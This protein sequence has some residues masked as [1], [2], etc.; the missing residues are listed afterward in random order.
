MNDLIIIGNGI[1]ANCFLW[2]LQKQ[3]RNLSILKIH[4]EKLA[5]SCSINS[6]ATISLRGVTKGISP[7][8]DEIFDSYQLA[9]SFIKTEKPDGVSPSKFFSLCD[10][11][12]E[13]EYLRRFGSLEQIEKAEF[14]NLREKFLGKIWGGYIFD[15]EKF[16]SFLQ[17]KNLDS[18]T[19]I[20]A[21]VTSTEITEKC[22]SVSTMEGATYRAK[23]LLICA[24]AYSKIYEKL[25][26]S[27][28]AINA[29]VIVPGAYLEKRGVD[30]GSLSFVVS[31]GGEN[32][33]YN[34][35]T[36]NLKIGAT[37]QK[38][39]IEAPDYPRLMEIFDSFQ[40]I[41]SEKLPDFSD[42]EVK[43]GLRQKGP[44]R[45]PFYGKVS[46]NVYGFMSLYK[47]GY[48]FPF[49]GAKKILELIELDLNL[50]K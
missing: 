26:P 4:N 42:F 27:L 15:P 46:S 3:K 21:M 5:P 20:S 36:H 24:G 8:G 28:N 40:S 48:T 32:L 45:M 41:F 17:R 29:S 7:L 19:S 31:K 2:E 47:N 6:T 43:V 9:E 22:V 49:L 37:S 16:L 33:I 44:K 35:I 14:L 39:G 12:E 30:L 1:A 11:D 18:H 38:K 23:K 13:D 10:K 50:D 25:Y 34:S